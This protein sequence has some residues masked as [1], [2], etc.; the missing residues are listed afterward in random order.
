[1][2]TN[3]FTV[4]RYALIN[5]PADTLHALINDFH[6]W[7]KW[8]PW[9]GLDPNLRRTYTGPASGVGSAYAWQGTRKVGSGDMTI[10]GS[11]PDRV[12][13]KLNFIKPFKAQNDTM[14]AIVPEGGGS[15]VTW[16]MTGPQTLLSKVMGVFFP[17]EK[18]VGKDFD[19]GLARLKAAAEHT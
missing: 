12:D 18:F 1:M 11:Q 5:A 8:S 17:M 4:E 19:K 7:T 9:E 2:A 13:I 15:R 14:F 3:T 16:T 10:V 6:E